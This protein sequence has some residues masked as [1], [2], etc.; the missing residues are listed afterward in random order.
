MPAGEDP[1]T[2]DAIKEGHG[3]V[4]S[5][6]SGTVL[7]KFSEIKGKANQIMAN[8]LPHG[9]SPLPVARSSVYVREDFLSQEPDVLR[10][11]VWAVPDHVGA[12]HKT[13]P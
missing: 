1:G 6:D 11:V 5:V 4:C 13:T 7:K 9:P 8:L 2:E 3:M 12:E 10:G